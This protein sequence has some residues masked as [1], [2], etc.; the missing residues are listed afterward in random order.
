MA[1]L[2]PSE[3][4]GAYNDA[5]KYT[6]QF[7]VNFDELE[8]LADNRVRTDLPPNYPR[9]NDGSL[10]ALLGEVPMRIW[11]QLQT[12][13]VVALRDGE[14][15]MDAYKVELANIVWANKIVPNANI[16]APFFSKLQTAEEDSFTYGSQFFYAF[17]V[18][19]NGVTG[20]D[21]I[22]CKPRDVKFEPGKVSDLDSDYMFLDTYYT[23][24]KIESILEA[25]EKEDKLAKKQGRDSENKWIIKVLREILDGDHFA[26][27]KDAEDQSEEE[28]SRQSY[29][30]TIKFVTCFHRGYGAPFY[31]FVPALKNALVR[32]AKNTNR[33][34][35]IP[36]SG[37]Y[38]KRN[39]KNP[40]GKGQVET[41]APTQNA[42]DFL[43]S[44]H[45]LSTQQGLEPPV[46]ISGNIDNARLETIEFGPNARWILGDASAEIK[47]T[48]SEVY[49]QFPN[50]YGLYKTQLM[51]H[52]GTSDNSVSASAGN[53]QYSKTPQGVNAQEE[54]KNAK[55]NFLRQRVDEA[56]ASLAKNLINIYFANMHGSEFIELHEE[57]R[58]R[59]IKA[60]MQIPEDATNVLVEY[61]ELKNARWAYDVDANSSMVKN[62]EDT[63]N[64][65][66]EMVDIVGR[67]P[68]LAQ[69][70]KDEGT[71]FKIGELFKQIFVKSGLDDWDKILVDMTPEEIA[72]YEAEKQAAVMQETPPVDGEV[73]TE[74]TLSEELPLDE[75]ALEEAG[76]ATNADALQEK[77]E[78]LQLGFDEST[79]H[80]IMILRRQGWTDEQITEHLS[81][82]EMASE[83]NEQEQVA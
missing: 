80:F 51:N 75:P 76:D 72:K 5:A 57:Q 81:K 26:A 10:S 12:G 7:Q 69:Q 50:S 47:D 32:E 11:A 35:D 44:G 52:L 30:K 21:F 31:T 4:G 54:R 9:V 58:D 78:L 2:K 27:D 23:R 14:D 40:Y 59:L 73:A 28:A 17:S 67:N 41:A 66:V 68:N 1:F 19:R 29:S 45:I 82:E 48:T 55:D 20:S 39:L 71:N 38:Y 22:V 33:T 13:R 74:E 63:K 37:I 77:N 64:R 6:R 70:L 65:L 60:G 36:L 3:L 24:L 56:L 18:A 49:T 53:P 79:A 15:E 25:A 8:R 46:A 83:L 16:Q 62:D 34:G 42:L 43:V 61:E